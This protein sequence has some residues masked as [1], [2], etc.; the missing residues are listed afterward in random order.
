[1]GWWKKRKRKAQLRE[2]AH[3]WREADS[4]REERMIRALETLAYNPP[5]ELTVSF[6]KATQRAIQRFISTAIDMQGMIELTARWMVYNLPESV[7]EEMDPPKNWQRRSSPD[8]T[9]K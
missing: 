8:D 4:E 3:W 2:Q 7:I 1:M 6:D 5:G 9:V